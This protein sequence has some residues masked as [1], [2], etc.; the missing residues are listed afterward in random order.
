MKLNELSITDLYCL[1]E[2]CKKKDFNIRN[3]G[4]G[5]MDDK[6]KGDPY[7]SLIKK[8]DIELEKRID[9]LKQI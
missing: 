6:K 8:I 4:M 1:L 5:F 9:Y 2:Y 7:N 3:Q